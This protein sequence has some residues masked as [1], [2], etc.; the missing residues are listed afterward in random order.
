[1]RVTPLLTVVLLV[2]CVGGSGI[3]R[4]N[5]THLESIVVPHFSLTN[6]PI[7]D[8]MDALAEA[9]SQHDPRRLRGEPHG[10]GFMLYLSYRQGEA[11]TNDDPNYD[12][13]SDE[14]LAQYNIVKVKTDP[15]TL[16][17]RD[18]NMYD[19]IKEVCARAGGLTFVTPK[20]G[21]IIVQPIG[22]GQQRN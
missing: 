8:A 6:A 3:S 15:V 22:A 11:E 10:F 2:G 5:K 4:A 18:A 12:F 13:W 21:L 20:R 9:A 16:D 19:L 17:V 14:A 1:M 7:G